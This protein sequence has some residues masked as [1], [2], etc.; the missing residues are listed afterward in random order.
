M[1]ND[2]RAL[3]QATSGGRGWNMWNV[4]TELRAREAAR[5]G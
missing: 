3:R 2:N 4:S 5:S 1:F